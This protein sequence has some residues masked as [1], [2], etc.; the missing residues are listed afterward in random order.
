MD[1]E[2]AV[3]YFIQAKLAEK[4]KNYQVAIENYS[5]VLQYYPSFVNAI[6]G[7]ASCETKLG[8]DEDAIATY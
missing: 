4:E 7:K 6:Y 5:K 3:T 8:Q 1:N 2:D